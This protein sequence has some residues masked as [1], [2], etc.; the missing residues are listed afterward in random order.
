MY[1]YL[2]V[3]PRIGSGVGPGTSLYGR[4][5]S[6][7]SITFWFRIIDSGFPLTDDVKCGHA[8]VASYKRNGSAAFA[9]ADGVV[10]AVRF[11][12]ISFTMRKFRV[13]FIVKSTEKNTKRLEQANQI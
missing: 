13:D 11:E 10:V 9:L 2:H 1:I 5:C 12:N 4:A 7:V 6:I 3:F 8:A